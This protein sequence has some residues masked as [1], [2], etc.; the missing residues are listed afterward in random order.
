MA[1][2]KLY[3]KDSIESLSPLEFTRLKPGVYAGDTTYSTQLLVEIISNAVDEFRLGHGKAIDILINNEDKN[4]NI[5][6][7]D[8]GQGFLV[9]EIREDGKSV[10]EAAFSV[11]NTSGKYRSDGTYEGTSL[12]SFGIGSKITTFL[13]HKLKVTTNRDGKSETVYFK[14]GVFEKRETGVIDSGISGTTVEWTPSEE[15]FTHTS[16]EESKIK[17][18]LNTISC[19]CPGL[20]I[21]C[22]I[23]GEQFNYYS[24]HGLND[25]VDEAVKGKEI[26]TN[27]FNMQYSEGKEKLDMVLTYTSNYSLTLVPYV[28]TGLTEK[29]PHITQVKTII[30]REFNKFFRDKKWLKD[31]DENLTGDDIQEGMY[32]VFNMTAPNVAYDA[33]V[34]STVTKLDMS[35]FASIIAVN[36][37]YWLASNEKEIKTIFDKAAAARKAR[38][39]AKNARER[40]R[41]TNKK[42]EKV[43]KF[44]S[45]LADCFSK[46]RS[47]CE[48]YI[49]EGDSA[50]GNLKTARDNEF[51]AVMP[52]RGK[53]LNTQKATLDKIQKN[54]EI[55]TMIEAFGL[56][57]DV[58][59]MKVTYE[60]EDLRYGK[61]IIMSDAD[62]DGA[63][64]KN[65][66][67]TF[68]WNFCPQL[69]QDGYV[70]AGVPPLY[71]VTI[72][73]EYK[74]IKNDEELEKFKK[75]NPTKKYTVNRMKGLGE[76]SVEETEQTLTN[77]NERI[78]K[79]ITV[80]DVS[81]ANV[82]FEQLMGTGVTARKEYIKLHSQ[83]AV[84]NAE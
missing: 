5:I 51:Q 24:E 34:K 4:T 80:D 17:S 20:H 27:R 54:A 45:K 15:F 23:N 55:M 56:T 8:Y 83:E 2:K 79:Q 21:N 81:A 46:D 41:E 68:I 65:L 31:K 75:E 37:Q 40:I 63:H 67:Y 9:N 29:G 1:D 43:L 73:K 82:L 38:E 3:T 10:L 60:P 12:G 77:P 11:L 84:Y 52:V 19:L 49:T 33:Q 30:T 22:N 76:M 72:G 78:L 32:I 16:V 61:I 36:L 58:K 71:K 70:Y 44:D 18:L 25:L 48:I 13:S 59:N 28:N 35:N 62:V 57:I 14:E 64:I 53:I 7:H 47:K 6:V 69:I 50:S 26:I 39:A 74:Y 66:F 42:K